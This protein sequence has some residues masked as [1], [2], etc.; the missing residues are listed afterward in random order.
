MVSRP[1]DSTDSWSVISDTNGDFV[2]NYPLDDVPGQYSVTATDG[3]NTAESAFLLV[4]WGIWTDKL[5]Y[6]PDEIVTIFGGGFEPNGAIT[7]TVTNPDNEIDTWLL[8][9]GNYGNFTTTYLLDGVPGFYQVTATDGIKE[10]TTWF[11]DATISLSPSS[12]PPGTLV[13]VSASGFG[14]GGTVYFGNGT[15]YYSEVGS[16][17]CLLGFC[18]GDFTVP[19]VPP[20]TYIVEAKYYHYFPF[21][22]YPKY[23]QI[24]P[25][26]GGECQVYQCGCSY[27]GPKTFDIYASTIFTVPG[28]PPDEAP[29]FSDALGILPLAVLA[30]TLVLLRRRRKL[31]SAT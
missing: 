3:I 28:A 26:F 31:P 16:F 13:S 18:A 5:N 19:D 1:D 30:G 20:G 29:L 14:F 23:C 2:T 17:V 8:S 24:C 22:C 12:G 21:W 15:D 25:P 9:A 4:Q 27:I 10:A 7:L 6:E 11:S